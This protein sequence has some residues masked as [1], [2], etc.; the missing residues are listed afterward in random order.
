M[1][2]NT[3]RK[4]SKNFA[5]TGSGGKTVLTDK[6]RTTKMIAIRGGDISKAQTATIFMDEMVMAKV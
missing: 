6:N 2:Q 4:S 1:Q 5:K 3:K